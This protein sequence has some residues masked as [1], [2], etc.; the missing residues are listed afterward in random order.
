MN[1]EYGIMNMKFN[2]LYKEQIGI[3]F[4]LLYENDLK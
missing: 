1:N 2:K 4:E 3:K